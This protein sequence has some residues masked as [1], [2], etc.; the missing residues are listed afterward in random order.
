M[1][2]NVRSITLVILFILNE[3]HQFPIMMLSQ[4]FITSLCG[5]ISYYALSSIEIIAEITVICCVFLYA[6]KKMGSVLD[7]A[8]NV[9]KHRL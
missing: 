5:L 8:V 4:A 9:L 7:T 1:C 2:V 6:V 3:I